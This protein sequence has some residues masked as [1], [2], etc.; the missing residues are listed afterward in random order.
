MVGLKARART[1]NELA[2]AARLYAEERPVK[3]DAKAA[4]ILTPEAVGLL[5]DWLVRLENAPNFSPT[6]LEQ[7]ARTFA[8]ER[9]IKLGELAQPLRAALTGS[10]ISPPVFEVA[11]IFGKD[12]VIAR[13]K[14]RHIA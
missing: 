8:E 1:L 7:S 3:P 2:A 4:A 13:L 5:E 12:E 14:D 6:I 10:T 11:S 9:G